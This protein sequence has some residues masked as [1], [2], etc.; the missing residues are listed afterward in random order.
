MVVCCNHKGKRVAGKVVFAIKEDAV[1]SDDVGL[2]YRT[3]E[4]GL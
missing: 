1:L 2:E 4:R 3:E